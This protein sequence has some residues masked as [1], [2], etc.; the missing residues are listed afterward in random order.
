MVVA[1]PD[2]ESLF[3]G[4][5]LRHDGWKII[6]VTNGGYFNVRRYEFENVMKF[7]NC[8]Y[9]MWNFKDNY[10]YNFGGYE[11]NLKHK[12]RDEI[13]NNNYEMVVTHNPC[14]EYGHPQHKLISNFVTDTVVDRLKKKEILYYFCLDK[15]GLETINSN[16]SGHT[17]NIYMPKKIVKI[18]SDDIKYRKELI[19]FYKTQSNVLSKTKKKIYIYVTNGTICNAF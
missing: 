11:N 7:S 15:K 12:I 9:E 19:K 8:E 2:D 5:L 14:G 6:C 17:N 4:H 13:I 10:D 3:A 16:M 1:H 18:D